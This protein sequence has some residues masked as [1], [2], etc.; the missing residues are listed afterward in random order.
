MSSIPTLL[1]HRWLRFLRPL[2]PSFV[3]DAVLPEP[4]PPAW[5]LHPT[6]YLDG[7]RGLAAVIVCICHYTE[8]NFSALTPSYGL[9]PEAAD[10]SWL[11]LPFLRAVF[12][13]RPMVHIFFVISGFVLSYKPVRA[14]HAGDRDKCYTTLA[15]STF[16]RGIR[17]FGPCLVS[18]LMIACL[19]QMGYLG[20]ARE[21]FVEEMWK[22]QAAI[23]HQI[24]WSWEW[25]RDL[26]PAYDVHLWTIPIEFAHSMLLFMTLLMLSRARRGVRRATVFAMMMY[27]LTCGKWAGFEF[28]AGLLLA[29]V[30]VLRST[31]AKEWEG[32]SE[33]DQ[34]QASIAGWLLKTFQCGLIVLGLFI[35][36]WPNKGA[37]DTPG[38]RYFLAQTPLPFAK[39][40]ALAPQKFWFGLSAVATVWAVGDLGFLRRFFEGP[41]AQY[42]GRISYAV[43]ICH[44]PVEELFRDWLLGHPEIP[45]KGEV[46]VADYHPALPATGVKGWIGLETKRQI[47]LGWFVGLW[48]LG[49]LVVWTADVF[50]RAVDN[51]V[52]SFARKLES[53]CLDDEE[54]S[55][56]SQGYSAAA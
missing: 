1:R 28:L 6:S 30:Y 45:A 46:G 12:S 18:T 39:M 16:R 11:Q 8:N 38:I 29:E 56:R 3:A 22:W 4:R 20:L 31:E 9:G 55:P 34:P 17:L 15:S 32:D 52:V 5:R 47:I 54:P 19:R 26:R 23:V 25:D 7:L 49:P 21:T 53:I 37:E 41:F 40:D 10:S 43:Y 2:L 50:W 44:G 24:T 42:C 36:G 27:C 35:G 48:L 14:L 33:T 13:G 51:Q